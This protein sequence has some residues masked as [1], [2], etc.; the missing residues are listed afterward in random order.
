MSAHAKPAPIEARFWTPGAF[1]MVAFMLTGFLFVI[2]RYIG[3]L[4]AVTNLDDAHPWGLW[5]GIDVPPA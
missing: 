3:G 5:I 2:A 4:A 1:V